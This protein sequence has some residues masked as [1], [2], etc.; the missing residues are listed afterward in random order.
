[1]HFVVQFVD[2]PEFRKCF[3]AS[4]KSIIIRKL[5]QLHQNRCPNIL[6]Y[7]LV[8]VGPCMHTIHGDPPKDEVNPI[9]TSSFQNG[10]IHRMSWATECRE[11]LG[12]RCR[13]KP[14]AVKKSQTTCR[15]KRL[16]RTKNK[17][18]VMKNLLS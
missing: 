13:E 9:G 7:E 11:K 14:C 5:T 2:L 4:N 18:D 3:N 8:S 16:P 15:E 6:Q 1:M 17:T 10:T 12:T